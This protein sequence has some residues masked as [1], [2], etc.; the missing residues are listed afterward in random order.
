MYTSVLKRL[1]TYLIISLVTSSALAQD[2]VTFQLDWLP[3]GDKA[4]VYVAIDKGFFAKQNLEVKI[5]HGRGSTDSLTKLAMGMSDIGYADLS[6]LLTAKA[7]SNIQVS[8]VMSVFNKAPHAFFTL[9][10]SGVTKASD[11]KGKRIATSAFTSSNVFLPLLME[12]NQVPKN[13]IR[14]I[15][16]DPGALGPMLVTGNTDV[17]I[18]W[19]TDSVKYQSQ[20][21]NIGKKLTVLPWYDA[22][23]EFYATV[24]IGNDKFLNN[25]PDIAKR[26]LIAYKKAIEFTWQHPQQAAEIVNKIVPE[27]DKKVA[28]E[29]ITS[30][31]GLVFNEVT[32]AHG[33]GAI[34]KE[35]LAT[36][37]SWVAKSQGFEH[38]KL[39]PETAINRSLLPPVNTTSSLVNAE[40]AL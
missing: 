2:K 10:D 19:L 6:S 4:P 20:A 11:I 28:L 1:G 5:S 25:K 17:V 39:D 31:K 15:K 33:L 38:S 18:S 40:A 21:N 37:W 3:G 12:L 27:V 16:A 36:S 14:F 35:R 22:G 24:L 8:A 32:K 23:L 34:N 26:F 7:Q 30:I 29:T 13:S 9:E